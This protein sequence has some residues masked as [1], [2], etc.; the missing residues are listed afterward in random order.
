VCESWLLRHY[1]PWTEKEL[2][3]FSRLRE[4]RIPN[5][6]TTANCTRN[7]VTN[8]RSLSSSL[9]TTDLS[10]AFLDAQSVSSGWLPDAHTFMQ[11][12][13]FK[14]ADLKRFY[15]KSDPR[16]FSP[17]AVVCEVGESFSF[18]SDAFFFLLL[19]LLLLLCFFVL[20]FFLSS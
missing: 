1:V 8:G 7:E 17:G 5:K 20:S 4:S 3:T 16:R 9:G 2:F 11:E 12:L 13:A 15:A 19:L 10:P 14:P 18:F 6:R